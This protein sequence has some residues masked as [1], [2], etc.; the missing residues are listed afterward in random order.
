MFIRSKKY[1]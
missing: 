1:W